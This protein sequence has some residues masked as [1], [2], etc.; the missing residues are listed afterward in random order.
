[1][2]WSG[3]NVKP[4]KAGNL[5]WAGTTG[6]EAGSEVKTLHHPVGSRRGGSQSDRGKVKERGK[7]R[8][9]VRYERGATV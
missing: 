6:P 5:S 2:V 7:N 3:R 1:V 8:P 9:K 4:R